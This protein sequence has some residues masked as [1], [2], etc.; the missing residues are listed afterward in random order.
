MTTYL[1][2]ELV[3]L[4]PRTLGCPSI[5]WKRPRVEVV[6]NPA[7]PYV[8]VRVEGEETTRAIYIDNL[9]KRLPTPSEPKLTMGRPAKPLV[10][11]E[12][13]EEVPLW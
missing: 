5:C 7:G 10:M 2:G 13:M 12:G 8:T 1:R 4:V 9:A 11:P 3:Y 6:D